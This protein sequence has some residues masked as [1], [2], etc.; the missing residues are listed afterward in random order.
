M[1]IQEVIELKSKRIK[2]TS[3]PGDF[4]RGQRSI[5][6]LPRREERKGRKIVL[7]NEKKRK[8]TYLEIRQIEGPFESMRFIL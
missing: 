5:Q 6:N 4:I 2:E 1:I 3:Q 7:Y 8:R